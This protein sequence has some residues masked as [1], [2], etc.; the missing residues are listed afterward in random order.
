M[1]ENGKVKQDRSQLRYYVLP[2]HPT[3]P[4][5]DLNIGFAQF[6]SANKSVPSNKLDPILKWVSSHGDCFRPRTQPL[7]PNESLKS[8]TSLENGASEATS[9]LSPADR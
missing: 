4:N 8:Q 6:T 3:R 7:S 5:F 9:P 2:A 1:D